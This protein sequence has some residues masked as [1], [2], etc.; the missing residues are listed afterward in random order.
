MKTMKFGACFCFIGALLIGCSTSETDLSNK[1][2][3]TRDP[4]EQMARPSG[5]TD[6]RRPRLISDQK[7]L[8][9]T[10]AESFIKGTTEAKII[11]TRT[12]EQ[13]V[14]FREPFEGQIRS[15]SDFRPATQELP[16]AE[17]GLPNDLVAG[18]LG[19]FRRV[20]PETSFPGISQTQWTPPDPAIAVGPNHI[21]QTVN[22]TV[23]FYDKSGTVQFQQLLN[24][25]DEPGFFDEVGSGDFVFDPKCYYDHYSNR[26]FIV[27]CEVYQDIDESYITFA[28]S[29]DDDPNGIWYKYRTYA[30]VEV[31][32][33]LYWVDYPGMGFDQDGMYITANLFNLAG[34]GPN[35]ANSFFRSFAK[36]PLLNG[37]PAQF[38]S[39]R[40]SSAAS[41]Q[42][43]QCFGDNQTPF[44]VSRN[45]STRLRVIAL[46]DPFDSPAFETFFV[47]VPEYSSPPDVANGQPGD[48]LN[49]VGDRIMNVHWRDGRLWTCHAIAATDGDRAVARWYEIDTGN[50][51]ASGEPTLVQSGNV[52]L[53]DGY[54]TFFPAVYTDANGNA[55][56]VMARSRAGDFASVVAAGRLA[57]DPLGT[58][59][60][61]EVFE[62]GSTSFGGR[63]GD[64]FDIALDPSDNSTF[65]ITGQVSE[66]FGWQTT[67]DSIRLV[68]PGD[69]NGD[70]IV[71]LL[72]VAPFIDLLS[73]GGYNPAADINND[74]VVDL[75]DV[76]P[77]VDL[78]SN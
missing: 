74:G 53:G 25:T 70:G 23:S 69:I 43:A 41:V 2:M 4:V 18:E 21:V 15:S 44:F 17:A 8:D 62:S 10:A 75:L 9:L 54:S 56:L 61:I 77:F 7:P 63:W 58:M 24:D 38:T 51:P 20:V 47:D 3:E 6:E 13:Q 66:S 30:V 46:N 22:M 1:Q 73:Q 40:N 65:W 32:G 35:F 67:V 39:I 45:T 26:F 52:D 78:L 68:L 49:P 72:D 27:A 14:R 71:N 12:F 28:V 29:D 31:D 5:L 16:V 76:A 59:S 36:E 11:D 42:A 55:A 37:Q 50:W 57:S 19:D 33:S 48:F 64:Y 34:P 60:T